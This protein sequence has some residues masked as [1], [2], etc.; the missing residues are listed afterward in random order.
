MSAWSAGRDHTDKRQLHAPPRQHD[1]M[2]RHL[3][4]VKYSTSVPVT[5]RPPLPTNIGKQTNASNFNC[6]ISTDKGAAQPSAIWIAPDFDLYENAFYYAGFWKIR[7]PAGAIS[8]RRLPKSNTRRECQI[9]FAK[10][11]RLHPCV[12]QPNGKTLLATDS[13][14]PHYAWPPLHVV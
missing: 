14:I 6:A 2:V 12:T 1:I 10:G 9:R 5:L 11:P 7:Y 3:T 4:R 8:T 13:G